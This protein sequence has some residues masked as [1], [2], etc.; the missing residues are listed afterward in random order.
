MMEGVL[1]P[2]VV[3][4]SPALAQTTAWPMDG[5]SRRPVL[6]EQTIGDLRE[7]VVRLRQENAELRRENAELRQE[8]GYWKS[9]HIRALERE[10]KLA[11][12]PVVFIIDADESYSS[13]VVP[14]RSRRTP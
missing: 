6:W 3:S 11:D 8:S 1:I 13:G 12:D 14:M 5:W 7:E 4:T 2:D 10:A 9:M